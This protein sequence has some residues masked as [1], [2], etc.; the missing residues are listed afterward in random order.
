MQSI[1]VVDPPI[2][3]LICVVEIGITG[4]AATF[5]ARQLGLDPVDALLAIFFSTTLTGQ[6][7]ISLLN[8]RK[9]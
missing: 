8:R 4:I 1:D 2:D 6:F 7:L 5:A 9:R 3:D